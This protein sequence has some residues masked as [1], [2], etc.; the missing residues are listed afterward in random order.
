MFVDSGSVPEERWFY[1]KWVR[2]HS[3]KHLNLSC[4]HCEMYFTPSRDNPST[5]VF[6]VLFLFRGVCQA[7]RMNGCQRRNARNSVRRAGPR[8]SA[9]SWASGTKAR[10]LQALVERFVTPHVKDFFKTFSVFR[11]LRFSKKAGKRRAVF[12]S[13]IS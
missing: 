6:D 7:S 4:Q 12:G 10:A 13:N 3:L 9:Y 8:W 1:I 11:S 2:R 5:S